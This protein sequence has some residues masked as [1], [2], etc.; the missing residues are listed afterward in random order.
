MRHGL[1]ALLCLLQVAA[2]CCS[3]RMMKAV[4]TRTSCHSPRTASRSG[5]RGRPGL[6][7]RQLL[8]INS[9]GHAA[10]VLQLC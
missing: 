5:E 7:T 9:G 10:Q 3:R 1:A 8:A 4:C 6:R 2:A